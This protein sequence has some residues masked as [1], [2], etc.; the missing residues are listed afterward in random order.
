VTRQPAISFSIS[1]LSPFNRAG[2]RTSNVRRIRTDLGLAACF[3]NPLRK[4][5]RLLE[6]HVLVWSAVCD[7]MQHAPETIDFF[8]LPNQ[9]REDGLVDP[10]SQPPNKSAH[11]TRYLRILSVGWFTHWLVS[12]GCCRQRIGWPLRSTKRMTRLK[13]SIITALLC[14]GIRVGL[15]TSRR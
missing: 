10:S 8:L 2:G 1:I 4:F 14:S 7:V 5:G 6:V 9:F 3:A 11:P 15:A 13:I 12:L